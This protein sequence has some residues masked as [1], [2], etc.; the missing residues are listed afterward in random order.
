M[1]S[2]EGE[3]VFSF[4][5]FFWNRGEQLEHSGKRR[6]ETWGGGGETGCSKVMNCL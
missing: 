3:E 6:R 1:R 2:L 4:F 5:V